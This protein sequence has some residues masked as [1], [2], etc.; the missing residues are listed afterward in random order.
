MKAVL[1]GFVAVCL[2]GVGLVAASPA[3]ADPICVTAPNGH[4]LCL[5]SVLTPS[6]PVTTV[7]KTV[8]PPVHR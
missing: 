5:I 3:Q 8:K 4:V 6:G 7:P 2:L 1:V